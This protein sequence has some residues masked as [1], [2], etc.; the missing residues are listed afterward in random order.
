VLL[1]ALL[2]A[3]I[4]VQADVFNL[5]PGL[6][7]LETVPVGDVGN[8]G[9]LSGEGAGGYGTNRICGSV[10]YNYN[11]GKYEVTAAQY[12][13]FLN[14]KAKSDTYWLYNTDMDT[15]N[16][17]EGCN[18]KRSGS[19]GNY[20]Y[21]VASDWANRP[22]NYVSFWDACRFANWLHNGQGDGDTETG[23]YTLNGYN[24]SDGRTIQRNTDWTWAVTSEDEWYKA[25]YYKGGGTNVGYWKYPTQSNSTPS[26][27]VVGPDPGNNANFY[28]T[29]YPNG[30]T[31]GGPYW[32]TEVGEFE[33]SESAYGTFDQGGN[34]WELNDT[35]V[36][37]GD[38]GARGGDFD[39]SPFDILLGWDRYYYGPTSE[40]CTVGFRVSAVPEPSSLM[41]LAGGIGMVLGARRRRA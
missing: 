27:D 10:G 19:E 32:R 34:V 17:S 7:N 8:I 21:S 5:G 35:I 26:N 30:Y 15:L 6:T 38:R 28:Q 40:G 4:G 2:C 20:A 18:I 14:A 37:Q 25:A 22:V 1:V 29:G 23:A 9:E 11:I 13:E 16:N 36:Y 3:S 12:T 33:N 24:G 39:Y 31:I 41:I